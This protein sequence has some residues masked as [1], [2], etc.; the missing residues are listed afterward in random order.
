MWKHFGLRESLEGF[1]EAAI[2][3]AE[4]G[5]E[6]GQQG[7]ALEVDRAAWIDRADRGVLRVFGEK[8]R[9]GQFCVFAPS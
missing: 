5:V 4:N 1:R 3:A 7:R 2:G 8:A 9:R 6:V